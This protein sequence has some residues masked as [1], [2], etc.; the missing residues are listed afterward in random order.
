VR[1]SNGP[2]GIQIA[3]PKETSERENSREN[4]SSVYQGNLEFN[5]QEFNRQEFNR[6]TE[7]AL[8]AAPKPRDFVD[9]ISW[10][11]SPSV[12]QPSHP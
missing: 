1:I 11:D 8:S 9:E 10:T 12:H 7:L 3:V 6:Q 2:P 4:G 5:R